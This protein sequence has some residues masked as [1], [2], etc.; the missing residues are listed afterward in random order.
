MRKVLDCVPTQTPWT[1]T[2]IGQEVRRKG[3]CIEQQTVDHCLAQLKGQG[4]LRQQERGTY[5]R[6]TARPRIHVVHPHQEESLMPGVSQAKPT[7]VLQSSAPSEVPSKKTSSSEADPLTRLADIATKARE[8]AVAADGLAKSIEEAG[9]DIQNDFEHARTET[10][11]FRQLQ[12]LLK[13]L[14]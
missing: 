10:E 6:I 3:W 2:D 7:E 8:L 11:K 13:G 12:A 9:L 1:K 4:L 5:I 14:V